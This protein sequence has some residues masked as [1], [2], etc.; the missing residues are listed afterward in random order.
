MT[1]S[2]QLT[3]AAEDK[4]LLVIALLSGGLDSTVAVRMMLDQGLRVLALNFISP[5][6]TCSPRKEGGCRLAARVA[7]EMGVELRVMNKGMDY[8]RIVERPRF[9][10]GRGINP[11]IDC[12]IYILRK[13]AEVMKETG[14][15]CVVTG[16]VLGQR[17]MSQHR[18]ALDTI[19]RESGLK[20]RLLRPLSAHLL[21][22]TIPEQEGLIQRDRL[23]ALSG[24]TRSAQLA[25]AE[26]R[27]VKVF[28]C[29]SGGCLL[30]NP[31][32][33]RRLKDVFKRCENWDERD[34]R[35]TTLGRHFRLHPGLKMILSRDE[36]ETHALERLAGD[37]PAL[38]LK[39]VPGPT[40]VLRGSY[41]EKDL[42]NAGRLL[43]HFSPKATGDQ[44][45]VRMKTDGS[46]REWL[47]A[48]SATPGEV[49]SWTI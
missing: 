2:S 32:I 38:A 39:G 37:K 18:K 23:L 11:C 42:V 35:L 31:L 10:R 44:V 33:A 4:R 12:R 5:F 24:R 20:G 21:P 34:A 8:L 45:V 25:I 41:E 6:C 36:S 30:T 1:S 19:E 46:E 48:D 27:K 40:G 3:S 29:P 49:K 47:V 16:E 22:P 9:G 7:Q 26:E 14:A 28:G 43:R 15:V 13:A 17:P